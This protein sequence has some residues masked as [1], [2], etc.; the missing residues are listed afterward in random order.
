MAGLPLYSGSQVMLGSPAVKGLT[1][2]PSRERS[3]LNWKSPLTLRRTKNIIFTHIGKYTLMTQKTKSFVK[4]WETLATVGPIPR[5]LE[6]AET[7]ARFRVT[8]GRDFLGVYLHWLDIA[9]N[10]AFPLCGHARMDGDHLP[11]CTGLAE[12]PA[13]DIVSRY[14]EARH[15]MVKKSSTGVG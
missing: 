3:R 15:Q 11:Q 7:V 4:P 9:A 5:H 8:T 1:K 6:R 13:D 10:E 2:K 12:Y 14:W